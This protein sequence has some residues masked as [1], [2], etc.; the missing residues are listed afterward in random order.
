M[1]LRKQHIF[2]YQ[3]TPS[4]SLDALL[5]LYSITMLGFY[6]IKALL[7]LVFTLFSCQIILVTAFVN[8]I[9]QMCVK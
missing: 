4:S 3:K 1:P 2:F 5:F 9:L 7:E 6:I 8:E